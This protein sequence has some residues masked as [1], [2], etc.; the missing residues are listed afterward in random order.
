MLNKYR[1]VICG[2]VIMLCAVILFIA[3]FSIKS[4]LGMNPGPEF[5]PRLASVL[6]FLVALGITVEGLQNVKHHIVEE[7]SEE[8]A[9]YRKA[10]NRKVLYSAILI[11]FYVFSL[12][13]L[14]FVISTLIYEFCQ[15]IVLTPLGKKKNYVLFGIITVIS[16]VF[17]YIVFTRFLYLMLPAGLLRYVGL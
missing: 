15:M 3:T 17:F 2:G 4:L 14:G 9:A 7:V 1:D 5:M 6:L 13:T 16:T 12:E 8:E 11:G 10:G